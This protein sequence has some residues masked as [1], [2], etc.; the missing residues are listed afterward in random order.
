MLENCDDLIQFSSPKPILNKTIQTQKTPKSLLDTSLTSENT[1]LVLDSFVHDDNHKVPDCLNESKLDRVDFIEVNDL[2]QEDFWL[3]EPNKLKNNSCNK[4]N[5]N[6]NNN[7]NT[8][9][10][11]VNLS[12]KSKNPY[13][14]I[15]EEFDEDKNL[16]KVKRTL[17]VT[18]DDISKNINRRSRSV[19]TTRTGYSTYYYH[20]EATFNGTQ[21]AP[22]PTPATRLYE[23][24]STPII[25]MMTQSKSIES[26]LN[27]S[28]AELNRTYSK[29]SGL[30]LINKFNQNNDIIT[31][32]TPRSNNNS[33]NIPSVKVIFDNNDNDDNNGKIKSMSSSSS[34]NNEIDNLD[35]N[36]FY[37]NLEKQDN[38]NLI[39]LDDDDDNKKYDESK[40]DNTFLDHLAQIEYYLNEDLHSTSPSTY[41]KLNPICSKCDNFLYFNYKTQPNSSSSSIVSIKKPNSRHSVRTS[42]LEWDNDDVL[43]A[44]YYQA[45]PTTQSNQIP[46]KYNTIIKSKRNNND[47]L[48]DFSNSPCNLTYSNENNNNNSHSNNSQDLIQIDNSNCHTK[49]DD[50]VDVQVI[51][52]IQEEDLRQSVLNLNKLTNSG[53]NGNGVGYSTA[54][55]TKRVH[56]TRPSFPLQ[57]P[58]DFIP[59]ERRDSASSSDHSSIS[60]TASN[61]ESPYN[62]QVNVNSNVFG[63]NSP[64]KKPSN[65][66]TITKST[67]ITHGINSKQ[68]LIT[69]SSTPSTKTSTNLS[70]RESRL[71]T[72]RSNRSTTSTNLNSSLNVTVKSAQSKSPSN[73]VTRNLQLTKP[74]PAPLSNQTNQTPSTRRILA[75]GSQRSATTSIVPSRTQ[76]KATVIQK[77]QKIQKNPTPQIPRTST[78]QSI[79]S[80]N[81]TSPSS[82][83]SMSASSSIHQIAPLNASSPRSR[84]LSPTQILTQVNKVISP[85]GLLTDGPFSRRDR[86]ASPANKYGSQTNLIGSNSN[87]HSIAETRIPAHLNSPAM[88][89]KMIVQSKSRK[90][91]LP[92]PTAQNSTTTMRQTSISPSRTR[93]VSPASTNWKDGCY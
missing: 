67:T 30:E 3:C 7:N 91:F 88:A 8:N 54:T 12:K 79:S 76:I 2:D 28:T 38:K 85:S 69:R 44:N 46:S 29:E 87:L 19:S 78:N 6:S 10:N 25:S 60:S 49:Y 15:V 90:S 34:I 31:S 81:P 26:I 89:R 22:P 93:N 21:M 36:V 66:Q 18:L 61:Y 80:N 58:N 68:S 72:P 51:A 77:N 24:E 65:Y 13:K 17:L 40:D 52:N 27:E 55:I 35:E 62:S 37:D 16:E 1:T 47:N 57:L 92:Q 73:F 70:N 33:Y 43:D 32:T 4:E 56:A 74:P 86:S 20:Q 64:V 5:V 23:P 75:Y 11:N 42:S 48:I 71:P 14:W 63:T 39:V 83:S 45:P 41:K 82:T 59:N 84:N 9:A 50:M 53:A